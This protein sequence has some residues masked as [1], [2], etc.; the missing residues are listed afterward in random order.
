MSEYGLSIQG[1]Y[2][3]MNDNELDDIVIGIL[4]D[5]PNAEYK[6]MTGLCSQEEYDSRREG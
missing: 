5:F 6:R 4:K 3:G 2:D 1:S